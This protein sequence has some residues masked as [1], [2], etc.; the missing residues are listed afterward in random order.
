MADT[1]V[2]AQQVQTTP[3]GYTVPGAQ[4][5]QVK[6]VR[7]VIDGSGAGGAFTPV[8]QLK[9]PNGT[10]VWQ[11][12]GDNT[13]AAGASADVSWFPRVA[14]AAAASST[15]AISWAYLS[16]NG[17]PT[18]CVGNANTELIT[19]A[20]TFYTNDTA[21]F[22]SGALAAPANTGIVYSK[23]GHYLVIVSA[24]TDVS[25][26]VGQWELQ[27][28]RGGGIPSEML[29]GKS[30]TTSAVASVASELNTTL[31]LIENVVTGGNPAP[32]TPEA[33]RISNDTATAV[34]IELES[35]LCVALDFVNTALIG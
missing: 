20:T 34:D 25:P 2:R 3:A 6:S 23:N 9:D 22:T 10:I 13:I 4:V 16:C 12:P 29:G 24:N 1:V 21:T 32:T 11:A 35:V 33:W 7:A 8:L 17:A 19:D 26:G 18:H 15:G 14:A 28:S 30:G 31:I 5:I 27:Q